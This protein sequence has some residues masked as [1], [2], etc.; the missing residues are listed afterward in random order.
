MSAD[1]KKNNHEVTSRS[2]VGGGEAVSQEV[3]CHRIRITNKRNWTQTQSGSH[4]VGWD[5][6][7]QAAGFPL[8]VDFEG[9]T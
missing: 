4:T 2:S 9:F 6:G 8:N 7:A 3:V 5:A 1:I